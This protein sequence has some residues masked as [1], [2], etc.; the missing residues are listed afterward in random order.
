MSGISG[1]ETNSHWKKIV[2]LPLHFLT[3]QVYSRFGE[4]FRDGQYILF[5]FLLAVLLLTVPCPV[6]PA[7]CKK[8]GGRHMCPPVPYGVGATVLQFVC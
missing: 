7:I 5:S 3:L 4:R 2:L 1:A 8:S 6:C